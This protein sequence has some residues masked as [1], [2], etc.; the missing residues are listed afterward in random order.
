MQ[1]KREYF[2]GAREIGISNKLTNYGILAFLEDIA[3]IHSDSVGYGVKDVAEKKKAWILMDWKLKVIKRAGFGEK[4]IVKTW[5]K[6]MFKPQ[7]YTYRDFEVYN[8]KDEL[9]AIA[10]SKWVFLDTKKERISKIDLD[11]LKIYNPDD[12]CV[13][14]KE[15]IEKINI[16]EMYESSVDY[17]VKRFDIDVNNHVHNLNYLNLAYEALPEEVYNTMEFNNVRITYKHQIRLGENVKCFYSN[18][19]EDYTI[20]IKS[21]DLSITHA[22]IKLSNN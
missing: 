19:N 14:G 20:V 21:G 4:I 17:K 3:G 18:L 6:T 22:I 15:E 16:P 10:T 11:V 7:F 1:F 8:E 2:I 5:A 13:F 9:I 12:K